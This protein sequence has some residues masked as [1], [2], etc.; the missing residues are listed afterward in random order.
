MLLFFLE[1]ALMPA[2]TFVD[3]LRQKVSI[4]SI[5]PPDSLAS[6]LQA[7]RSSL[8]KFWG[9]FFVRRIISA[10]VLVVWFVV[11]AFS[12]IG[13]ALPRVWR[14]A[15]TC[16]VMDLSLMGWVECMCIIISISSSSSFP[17]AVAHA[18]H[19]F[20]PFQDLETQVFLSFPSPKSPWHSW[21]PD[22]MNSDDWFLTGRI[23]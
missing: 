15:S 12:S 10:V 22:K 18:F 17:W 5:C 9:G 7:R 2:G 1:R 14:L 13:T 21:A 19:T 4:I 11:L 3:A 20:A 16:Q 8:S 6:Q 23:W